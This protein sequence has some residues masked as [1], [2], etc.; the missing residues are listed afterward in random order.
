MNASLLWGIDPTRL[1]NRAQ[2]SE[3]GKRIY[4]KVRENVHIMISRGVNVFPPERPSGWW[5]NYTCPKCAEQLKFR[6]DSP[7]EHHCALCGGNFTSPELNA[8][9]IYRYNQEN[10][11]YAENACLLVA[12]ENDSEA[13][14]WAKEI[15]TGYAAKYPEYPEHGEYAGRGRIQA[16]SLDEAVWMLP[17]VRVY[18]A[19]HGFGLLRDEEVA[20]VCQ[21]MFA[22][23][24]DLLCPQTNK[25]HNIH[26][27]T[28]SAIWAM[29][30]ELGRK[31]DMEFAEKHI[32]RNA[33]EGILPDGSWYEGSPHYHFYTVDAFVSYLLAARS[34]GQ[35]TT[36]EERVAA[37]FRSQIR[38][39]QPNWEFPAFNDG[40]PHNPL[41]TRGS[42][43]EIAQFL[44]GNFEAVLHTIYHV[45]GHQRGSVEALLY[46]QDHLEPRELELPPL[47]T[48]DGVAV[49]RRGDYVGYVKATPDGGGHDHDDKPGLYFWGKG[50]LRAADLGNPGYG[51][52]LHKAYFR[53]SHAHNTVV[54]DDTVQQR[55]AARIVSAEESSN[56]TKVV[57][58][59]AGAYPGVNITRT[60]WFG[61][62]WI[63]DRTTV[64]S[65]AEHDYLWLFHANG[66]LELG[67]ES[68]WENRP[69]TSNAYF[70]GQRLARIAGSLPRAVWRLENEEIRAVILGGKFD[71]VGSATG[72][73]LPATE[74]VD[75]LAVTSRGAKLEVI[76]AF[77]WGPEYPELQLTGEEFVVKPAGN[78]TG[79]T[80]RLE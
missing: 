36:V 32:L 56:Y 69:F 16:Q 22:P 20:K 25:V 15:L 48:V 40:W 73:A 50:K 4:A 44:F 45:I 26:V 8:A 41:A 51:N 28:A 37:M 35:K 19:L 47:A 43:F 2:N 3:W 58:E 59:N 24:V 78:G 67:E 49:V 18:R 13:G 5:H 63:L 30:N 7:E 54:V 27:W 34:A 14:N 57:A 52:P 60:S 64:S 66:R 53:R 29:A 62:N 77:L 76:I 23:A 61:N 80:V 31:E 72:P 21:S 11:R 42:I 68:D 39:L 9:W 74:R 46:G 79:V 65:E 6:F 70:A 75:Y 17:A 33:Q 55:A 38:L 12:V 1:R 71:A 10:I